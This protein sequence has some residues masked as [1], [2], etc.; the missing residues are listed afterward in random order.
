MNDR[1]NE[2]FIIMI[3]FGLLLL[4]LGGDIVCP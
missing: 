4:I 3:G 2:A 1:L